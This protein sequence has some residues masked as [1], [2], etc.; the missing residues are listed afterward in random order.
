MNERKMLHY[1]ET[2]ERLRTILDMLK[3]KFGDSDQHPVIRWM[4]DVADS[5]PDIGEKFVR[6]R[7]E[8]MPEFDPD[9]VNEFMSFV[10][11]RRSY[12]V[13]AAEQP[14]VDMLLDVARK[15]IE[16]ASHAPSSGNRQPWRFLVFHDPI[17]KSL[18][19]GLKEKH[20]IEAPVLIFVGMDR[21]VYGAMGK[22]ETGVYIDAGAAIMQMLLCAEAIGLG[23]CW[24][25]FA[26]DLIYSRVGNPER[27]RRFA[28]ELGIPKYIEPIAIVSVGRPA[29]RPPKPARLPVRELLIGNLDLNK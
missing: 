13:W 4:T 20:C 27:Y 26:H 24:N 22:H 1:K 18:L 29:F 21:T 28:R 12:R 3:Q 5:Y 23:A 10:S 17:K 8:P 7:S 11:K 14:S 6:P 19:A 16:V 15:M 9:K 25:H 2:E